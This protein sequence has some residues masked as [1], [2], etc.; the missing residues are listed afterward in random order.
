MLAKPTEPFAILEPEDP[1]TDVLNTR[2]FVERRK[3]VKFPVGLQNI[4]EKRAGKKGG[5]EESLI[6][7]EKIMRTV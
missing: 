6:Y 3:I 1:S 4:A 5:A 7:Q 2:K